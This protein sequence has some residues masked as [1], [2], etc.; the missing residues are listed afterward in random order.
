MP[1][2]ALCSL[3]LNARQPD[4]TVG[5]LAVAVDLGGMGDDH[6]PVVEV[7]DRPFLQQPLGGFLVKGLALGEIVLR[8]RLIEPGIDLRI[9]VAAVVLWRLGLV[10]DVGIAVGIDPP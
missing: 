8:S 4:E 1:T 6:Q 10:E 2:A 5:Q 3:Q 7:Y 9:A